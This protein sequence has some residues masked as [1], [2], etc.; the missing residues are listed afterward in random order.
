MS[1]VGDMVG[2]GGTDCIDKDVSLALLVLGAAMVFG[3]C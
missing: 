1:E 3:A 2:A